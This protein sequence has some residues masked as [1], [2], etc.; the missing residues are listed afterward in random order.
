M[1][2]LRLRFCFLKRII[3]SFSLA[4]YFLQQSSASRIS[5]WLL[6]FLPCD[7]GGGAG[8]DGVGTGTSCG[9][10]GDAPVV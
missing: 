1:E 4:T 2:L 10:A 9:D 3:F 8:S 5:E 7:S 6:L